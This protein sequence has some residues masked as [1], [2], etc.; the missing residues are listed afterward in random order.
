MGWAGGNLYVFANGTAGGGQ[1]DDG[2]LREQWPV[3][4]VTRWTSDGALDVS[5]GGG[6]GFQEGG[7]SPDRKYW[8]AAGV[9]R[10]SPS[11]FLL[12]GVA[13][14]AEQV[15][16]TTNGVQHTE[17]FV[18]APQPALFRVEDPAG[19]DLS[20]GGDGSSIVRLPEVVLSLKAAALLGAG[21]VRAACVDVIQHGSPPRPFTN[22]GGLVQWHLATLITPPHPPF[23]WPR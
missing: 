7:F 15:T 21:Q 6:A 17:T 5:L 11:T 8:G 12:Y 13:G 1:R 10:D 20:F 2:T 18:R 4:L 16:T 19:L 23:P 14:K 9:L 22:Q 3:L